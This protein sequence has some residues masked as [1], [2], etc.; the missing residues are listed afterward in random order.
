M[1]RCLPLP[2]RLLLP[3][4]LPLTSAHVI[5]RG[6]A[7]ARP[8]RRSSSPRGCDGEDAPPRE[9]EVVAHQ[10]HEAINSALL[11]GRRHFRV[12]ASTPSL[13]PSAAGYE[14]AV[15]A[16]LALECMRAL[17]VLDGQLLLLLPGFQAAHEAYAQRA[18]WR[19]GDVERL[20]VLDVALC[21]APSDG[22]AR[23]A[24]VLVAGGGAGG[25]GDGAADR[26]VRAWL[27]HAGATVCLNCRV[28]MMPFERARYETVFA[29]EPHSICRELLRF[30]GAGGMPHYT[31]RFWVNS[32]GQLQLGGRTSPEALRTE[33]LGEALLWRVHPGAW[34]VLLDVGS[35]GAFSLVEELP[36]RPNERELTEL[37]VPRVKAWRAAFGSALRALS[38][39]SSGDGEAVRVGGGEE[40]LEEGREGR[41]EGGREARAAG[42]ATAAEGEAPPVVCLRW[43]EIQADGEPRALSLYQAAALLRQRCYGEAVSFAHDQQALHLLRPYTP[44]EAALARARS[45]A[46]G[47]SN[48]DMLGAALV[49]PDGAGAGIASLEQLALQKEPSAAER[50]A[51]A[52]CLLARAQREAA[53]LG[54]THLAVRTLP[55]H[56]QVEG[57]RWLEEA[58]FV[59][60]GAEGLAPEGLARAL[61]GAAYYKR[62]ELA[63]D[64]R[65]S[66]GGAS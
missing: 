35:S 65:G 37:L 66:A 62:L 22:E 64:G 16:R 46:F 4:L 51:C 55:N 30:P 49:I 5:P 20:R 57:A 33:S 50:A 8:A 29:L 3:L 36:N 14:P 34:R 15:L 61:A 42:V 39:P 63:T 48:G 27:R 24:A 6:A 11:S 23:A 31:E 53:A 59:S 2:R 58:G 44:N 12:E 38:A 21:P 45:E 28:P 19:A 52:A 10:A 26:H 13:D 18:E 32:Y 25:V 17:T 60:A 40:G 47:R 54:H 9:L 1:A 41:A 43:E 7:V 56:L